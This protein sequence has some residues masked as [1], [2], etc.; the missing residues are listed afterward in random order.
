MTPLV[1]MKIHFEGKFRISKRNTKASPQQHCHLDRSA[2]QSRDL[3]FL[4]YLLLQNGFGQVAGMVHIDPVLDGQLVGE[5]L[6]RNDLQ[7]R[8]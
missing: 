2:V 3:R 4:R 7:H 1:E 5:Q 6:Q 8:G